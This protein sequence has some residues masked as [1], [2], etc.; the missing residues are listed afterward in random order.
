MIETSSYS[1]SERTRQTK[2]CSAIKDALR[3]KGHATNNELLVE[4]RRIFPEL[5]ATTVPRA[6]TRLAA[7]GEIA[8][9]PSATDGSM[10]YEAKLPPHDHFL[11]TNCDR[12]LNI[13]VKNKLNSIL[14]SSICDCQVS[15]RLTI[16]GICNRCTKAL[17][18][19]RGRE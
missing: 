4:L 2:Y 13:D 6:T 11:C 1:S 5:S 7:R 12:L 14:K 18:T 10:R 16:E 17:L 19:I 8:I 15:G 9:A 3:L